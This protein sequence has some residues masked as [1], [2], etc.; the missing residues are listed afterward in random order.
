MQDRQL[1]TEEQSQPLQEILKKILEKKEMDRLLLNTGM[2]MHNGS[3]I[4]CQLIEQIIQQITFPEH[5]QLDIVLKAA[6]LCVQLV[7]TNRPKMTEVV[8]MLTEP[9]FPSLPSFQLGN[10][11]A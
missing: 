2:T 1:W 11:M 4:F 7:P 3:N 5:P 9:Q 6:R 8:A 10:Y